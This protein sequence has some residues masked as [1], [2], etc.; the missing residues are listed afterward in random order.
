MWFHEER[1]DVITHCKDLSL[2][3]LGSI[4][5][6]SLSVASP[7]ND[8]TAVSPQSI[9]HVRNHQCAPDGVGMPIHPAMGRSSRPPGLLLM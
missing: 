9:S 8:L 6:S 2:P 7:S 5:S 4:V 1:I 3:C